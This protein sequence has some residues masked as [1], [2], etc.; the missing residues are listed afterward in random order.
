MNFERSL[1]ALRIAGMD[2]R[3]R[4][5]IQ[6]RQLPVQRWPTLGKAGLGNLGAQP[7]IGIRQ[8]R[9]PSLQGAK[10]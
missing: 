9:Q 3:R 4:H 1:N 5:R 6:Y 8:F 7:G 2:A 10:I